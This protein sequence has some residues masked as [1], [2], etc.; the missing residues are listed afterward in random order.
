[1]RLEDTGKC[2]ECSLRCD[3]VNPDGMVSW[4]ERAEGKN[5]V[6]NRLLGKLSP[7]E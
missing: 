4:K 1:M 3:E 7:E 5:R 2:G 6:E